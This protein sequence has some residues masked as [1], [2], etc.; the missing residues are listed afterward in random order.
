MKLS[1]EEKKFWHRNFR[2]EKADEIP[3]H[4]GILKSADSDYDD[5]F[6]Y[7]LS[8][9]VESINEIYLKDSQI[10]DEAIKY[11]VGF[12]NLKNLFLRKNFYLTKSCIPY[13]NQMETLENL[14]L[15]GT[16]IT[17]TDI[18]EALNNKNLKEVFVS[19][20]EIEDNLEE[21][22]FTLK[23]RMPHCNIYLD[24]S[25]STDVFGNLEKPIF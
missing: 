13:F 21:K 4:W 1:K 10:T 23:E 25:Y 16:E 3:S 18:F 20:E 19:S 5:E 6:F 15:T 11:M 7:F 8:L 12:K 2:I 9:R 22:A 24:C 17:L 14:N